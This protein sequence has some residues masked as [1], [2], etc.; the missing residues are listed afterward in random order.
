[1]TSGA[2]KELLTKKLQTAP[3]PKETKKQGILESD[4]LSIDFACCSRA[5]AGDSV[6]VAYSVVILFITSH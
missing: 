2:S 1:M 3:P 6:R 5:K 4:L